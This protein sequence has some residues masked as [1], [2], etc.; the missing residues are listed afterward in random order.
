[1]VNERFV[2]KFKSPI[3]KQLVLMV[4]MVLLQRKSARR[5]DAMTRLARFDKINSPSMVNKLKYYNIVQYQYATRVVVDSNITYSIRMKKRYLLKIS[6]R[7]METI[8]RVHCLLFLIRYTTAADH[9]SPRAGRMYYIDYM[10][11]HARLPRSS[12]TRMRDRFNKVFLFFFFFSSYYFPCAVFS[13]GIY[14]IILLL[15]N[16]HSQIHALVLFRQ[17]WPPPTAPIHVMT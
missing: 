13:F 2:H 14:F 8:V 12:R 5:T 16:R 6:G 10:E 4:L 1:M 11:G 15:A 7:L 17:C 9:R 3:V